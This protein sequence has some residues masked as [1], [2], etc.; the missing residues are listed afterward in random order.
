MVEFS[1]NISYIDE[2]T[3]GLGSLQEGGS[4]S[5]MQHVIQYRPT[6][7]KSGND[8]QLLIDDDDPVLMLEGASQMQSPIASIESEQIE[9]RNRILSINGDVQIKIMKDLSY[10]GTVGVRKRTINEDVFYSERSKQAKNAGAPYGWKELEEQQSFMYNN[11]LTYDK[12][13]TPEHHLTLVG[14]QEFIEYKTDYLRSGARQFEKVNFGLADMSLGASP[15]KVVTRLES[16]KMLSYF[17]R[18]NYNFKEK[19]LF[20]A[21]IRADA[22]SKFGSNHKWGV[23]PAASFAWRASEEEFIKQLGVFSNLK[24]RLS[25]GTAG[26]N[27]ID[28]YLSLSKMGSVWIPYNGTSTA[29]GFVSKQL[30]NPDLQWETNVTANLGIDMGFLNQRLQLSVDLYNIETKNLLLDAPVPLLSGYKS[31]MINA[32]KLIIKVLRLLLLHIIY[33][34]KTLHGVQI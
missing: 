7:G 4:Y 17:M 20:A 30:Y 32:G 2:K 16:D 8:A 13:F 3:T 31:M 14:G 5:R 21:S 1:T 33:K 24:F 12:S 6:I 29:S 15:D 26:N 19:Y 22:S 18:A 9:K 27:K 10:R 23:F 25:Y 28:N 34:Q 11:V